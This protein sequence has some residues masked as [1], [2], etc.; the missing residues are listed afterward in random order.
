MG[1]GLT[2]RA[3]AYLGG[4]AVA[5]LAGCQATG[6]P[7]PSTDFYDQRARDGIMHIS[8]GVSMPTQ[9]RTVYENASAGPASSPANNGPEHNDWL[10]SLEGRLSA[11]IEA[12]TTIADKTTATNNLHSLFA[13]MRTLNE[14]TRDH[15]LERYV[16]TLSEENTDFDENYRE[17]S[18]VERA[19]LEN[20]FYRHDTTPENARY[21]QTTPTFL[22]TLDHAA[23]TSLQGAL[24]TNTEF[25]QALAHYRAGLQKIATYSELF[26]DAAAHERNIIAI[27]NYNQLGARA[28]A[29][30]GQ[31]GLFNAGHYVEGE[32]QYNALRS[33]QVSTLSQ[34]SNFVESCRELDVSTDGTVGDVLD[35]LDVRIRQLAG[36]LEGTTSLSRDHGHQ[37]GKHVSTYLFGVAEASRSGNL[38]DALAANK[39]AWNNIADMMRIAE[40]EPSEV[41]I[42]GDVLI[43][44]TPIMSFVYF[45]FNIRDAVSDD[46]FT[47]NSETGV[48]RLEQVLWWG[49]RK[50]LG[51]V[52]L[53]LEPDED[54]LMGAVYFWD[55]TNKAITATTF[56]GISSA[57]QLAVAGYLIHDSQDKDRDR[58][59]AQP[60]NNN[61]DGGG[62]DGGDDNDGGSGGGNDG[63]GDNGGGSGGGGGG[64][65]GGSSGGGGGNPGGGSDDGIGG[66]GGTGDATD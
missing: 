43:P 1:R 64:S 7:R 65:G 20:A 25:V 8:S 51:Y 24:P 4:L 14:V 53:N 15:R 40:V 22:N 9:A 59:S 13:Q 52:G 55:S 32:A 35:R 12:S 17:L 46:W 27:D 66:G 38:Q 61:N 48:G 34:S 42:V 10:S 44:M 39:Y 60:G 63:G 23:I 33:T 54:E 18:S 6:E 2:Y 49:R 30:L 26:A 28:R 21:A 19:T 16:A 41:R 37:L 3:K 56:S 50:R 11:S 57:V 36:E 31:T 29:L 62:N 47:P 58:N 5:A 45:G